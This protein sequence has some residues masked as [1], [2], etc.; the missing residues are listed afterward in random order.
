MSFR[1]V[2]ILTLSCKNVYSTNKINPISFIY[3]SKNTKYII[4]VR[5]LYFHHFQL[6]S[7]MAITLLSTQGNQ[8]TTEYISFISLCQFHICLP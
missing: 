7:H 6:C 2:A 3:L 5:L 4:P 1:N 8:L